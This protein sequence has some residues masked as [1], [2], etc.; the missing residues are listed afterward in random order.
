MCSTGSRTENRGPNTSF[1]FS[2]STQNNRSNLINHHSLLPLHLLLRLRKG[3]RPTNNSSSQTSLL[4]GVLLLIAH[5]VTN[6][7]DVSSINSPT[8]SVNQ[9]TSFSMLFPTPRSFQNRTSSSQ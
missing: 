2:T 7:H 1:A 4:Y 5:V 9:Q 3:P 8:A 6:S